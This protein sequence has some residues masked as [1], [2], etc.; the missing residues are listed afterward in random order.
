MVMQR[1]ELTMI[2]EAKN[3]RIW[4]RSSAW[5]DDAAWSSDG[6]WFAFTD[7]TGGHVC[8]ATSGEVV[9]ERRTL[10]R[11]SRHGVHPQP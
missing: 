5:V 10:P 3:E 1:G 2:D 7:S 4:A 6:R 11:T 8:D 9:Y